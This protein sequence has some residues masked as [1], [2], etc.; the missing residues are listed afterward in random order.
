LNL[1]TISV[2]VSGT[3]VQVTNQTVNGSSL[4]LTLDIAGNATVGARN[5]TVTNSQGESDPV[6]FSVTPPTWP[7]LAVTQV[8]PSLLGSGF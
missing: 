1:G 6:I 5:L 2:N 8:L 4:I 3:G 7:D